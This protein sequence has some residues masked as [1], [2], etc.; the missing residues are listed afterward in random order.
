M[1]KFNLNEL[2]TI[3]SHCFKDFNT[4]WN[5]FCNFKSDY[6]FFTLYMDRNSKSDI[7]LVPSAYSKSLN[8]LLVNYTHDDKGLEMVF[9]IYYIVRQIILDLHHWNTPL[10]TNEEHKEL[11]NYLVTYEYVDIDTFCNEF[12]SCSS[13]H[14]EIRTKINELL[15]EDIE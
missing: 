10:F 5:A 4:F 15:K 11:L 8:S 7:K 3:A 2:E 1:A 9:C 6:N 14:L 12:I 13:V